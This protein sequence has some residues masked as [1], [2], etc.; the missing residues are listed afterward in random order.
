MRNS[1]AKLIKN[2]PPPPLS[3]GKAAKQLKK[4]NTDAIPRFGAEQP[5]EYVPPLSALR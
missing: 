2:I 5:C 4:K 3:F 1:P